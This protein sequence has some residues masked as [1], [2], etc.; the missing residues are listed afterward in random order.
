MSVRSNMFNSDNVQNVSAAPI[1]NLY[2]RVNRFTGKDN[3]VKTQQKCTHVNT[4]TYTRIFVAMLFLR[5]ANWKLPPY[6]SIVERINHQL[7]MS[8][9]WNPQQ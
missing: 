9:P 8:I 3:F 1:L 6:P 2:D 7:S 5:A 4:K